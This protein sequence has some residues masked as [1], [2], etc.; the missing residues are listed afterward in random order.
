M[1]IFTLTAIALAI[2]TCSSA[3]PAHHFRHNTAKKALAAVTV[4]TRTP[5][6]IK[7][8]TVMQEASAPIYRPAHEE[9]WIYEDEWVKEADIDYT[10]DV[11]GNITTQLNYDDLSKNLTVYEYAANGLWS[12]QTQSTAE[13]SDEFVNTERRTRVFDNI[14]EDLVIESNAYNWDGNDWASVDN[15]HTWRRIVSRDTKGNITG[16]SVEVPGENSFEATRRST[17]TYNADGLADTWKYEEYTYDGETFFWEEFYTLTD[18]VWQ[19]TDGQI[20]VEDDLA[21]FFTG[22]NKLKSA[23]VNE[24]EIGVTGFITATYEDNGSYTYTFTYNGDVPESDVCSYTVTDANGSY[25]IENTYSVDGEAMETSKFE[26]TVNDYGEVILEEEFMDDEQLGG[27][28]NDLTYGSYD[29]P[30]ERIISEFDPESGEY[31]PFIKVISS[32]FTDITTNAITDT[33]TPES[34]ADSKV[35]DMLGRRVDPTSGNL[36]AGVY[37]VTGNGHAKK[38]LLN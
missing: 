27:V 24:P 10:Y 14:V 28:K 19:Q 34:P 20:T 8:R 13:G 38:I 6:F 16:I 7:T 33:A 35:Y 12:S 26:V 23:T 29:Y 4:S 21:A 30:E 36:P 1:K 11:L 9:E 5:A 22:D 37:I 17:I 15:G 18:L 2:A 32:D 3:A 31:L 25:T